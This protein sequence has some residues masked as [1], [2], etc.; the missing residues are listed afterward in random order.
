M[1]IRAP[2]SVAP[3]LLLCPECPATRHPPGKLLARR[4]VDRHPF[5]TH[6]PV[7]ARR[8]TTSIPPL[9]GHTNTQCPSIPFPRTQ[10]LRRPQTQGVFAPWKRDR[11]Q[12]ALCALL[13]TASHVAYVDRDFRRFFPV[14]GRCDS[15][16]QFR[17][18]SWACAEKGRVYREVDYCLI[19]WPHGVS[20]RDKCMSC[21][22]R[23]NGVRSCNSC[24]VKCGCNVRNALTHLTVYSSAVCTTG[25]CL[26]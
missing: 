14:W 11:V 21:K 19:K 4:E 13:P 22:R 3:R 5:P 12:R 10:P 25:L 26:L 24:G 16:D 1:E 7:I 8:R 2:W 23:T 18:S 6:P 9:F 17:D 20:T 15:G